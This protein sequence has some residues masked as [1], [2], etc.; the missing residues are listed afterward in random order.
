MATALVPEAAG[1]PLSPG[2]KKTKKYL[3]LAG[4][5]ALTL[6]DFCSSNAARFL[7]AKW[8]AEPPI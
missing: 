8:T 3:D 7:R 5:P 2:S 4:R 1:K 6:I